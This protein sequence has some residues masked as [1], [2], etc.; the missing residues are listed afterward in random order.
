[1]ELDAR[2]LLTMGGMLISVVSA[3]VIVKQKL[4]TVIEQLADVEK[5]LRAL[6]QR[7]DQ[8]ELTEQRVTTLSDMLAPPRREQLH[9]SLASMEQRIVYTERE[10]NHLRSM[11]NHRHPPIKEE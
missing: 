5:R 1:M 6:D 8:S 3:A 2:L 11:H 4:A 9:R 10:I 7:V